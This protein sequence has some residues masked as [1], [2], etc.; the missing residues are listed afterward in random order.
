[1]I[2]TMENTSGLSGNTLSWLS[3]Y[4]MPC[5]FNVSIEGNMSVDKPVT[6]SVPQGSVAG[7]I[8][9]NFY[10]GSLPDCIKHDGLLINGFADDH[11]LH[12]SYQMGDVSAE[13]NSIRTLEDSLH[14]VNDWMVQ[15][16]LHMNPSKMEC[17][18][19]GSK[20]MI[21][22]TTVTNI[23]VCNDTVICSPCIKLL[24]SYLDQSLTM[25]THIMKKC[26]LAMWNLSWIWSI[27][28]YMDTDSL[29]TTVQALCISHLDYS[30]ALLY[31]LPT[32]D[33]NCLQ[34][35]QNSCAKLV[36]GKTSYDSSMA[37]L[38]QL[39]WLPVKF[40]IK[41][42]ILCLMHGVDNDSAPV[43]LHKMVKKVFYRQTRCATT[44][45]HSMRSHW[46]EEE[47]SKLQHSLFQDQLSGTI[48]LST[49]LLSNYYWPWT[50]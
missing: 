6:F 30:N 11:M 21:K 3:S 25:S 36:L 37:C 41:F 44:L 42:K 39:H 34:L 24:G 17:I 38:K 5:R 23:T 16:K 8:L 48:F 40:R 19:F 26:S 18:S 27:K 4:L 10:V 31:G 50:I 46:L 9:F 1:M 22:I 13:T 33:I 12:N 7:P 28:S 15:N 14:S 49:C 43:Y 20:T 32:K 29:K 45:D 35:F 47:H 2:S